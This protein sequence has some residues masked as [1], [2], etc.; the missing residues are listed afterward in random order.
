V[1]PLVSRHSK[2]ALPVLAPAQSRALHDKETHGVGL[3]HFRGSFGLVR[4]MEIR[5]WRDE[6][7]DPVLGTILGSHS[8]PMINN[9]GIRS[10]D[11]QGGRAVET[12]IGSGCV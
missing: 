3:Y 10:M 6:G 1:L 11:D 5:F 2:S 4:G 7:L 9:H 12:A 8:F